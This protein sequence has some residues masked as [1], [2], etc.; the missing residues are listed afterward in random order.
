M[1]SSFIPYHFALGYDS[2]FIDLKHHQVNIQSTFTSHMSTYIVGI[3]SSAGGLEAL[4]A[5]LPHLHPNGLITYVIAQHMAHDGHSDLMEKLL[6]R[7]A[8]MQVKLVVGS[9]PLLPNHIYLIPAGSDGVVLDGKIDLQAPSPGHTSTP[10]VNVL[11]QSIAQSYQHHGIGVI[12]SGTGSDGTLGCRA[13]KHAQGLVIAQDLSSAG[14]DGMPSSAIEAGVVDHILDA[15]GIAEMISQTTSG[16]ISNDI[17]HFSN[18]NN[19]SNDDGLIPILALVFKKTGINFIGYKT[20]TLRRRLDT[21]IAGL[22]I[23]EL[24]AYYDYLIQ[25]ED[26]VFQLQQLFLVSFSSFFRDAESFEMLAHHLY[27]AVDRK[28]ENSAFNIWVPG[29]ASGEEVYTLAIILAEIQSK[30]DKKLSVNVRGTDLNPIA[31][32]QAKSGSY[33]LKAVKEIQDQFLQKYFERVGDAYVVCELIKSICQF[34][35]NNVIHDNE[36]GSIDLISCRNLLIYLKG[37]L[38]DQLVFKFHQA[39]IPDGMLFLGQSETLSPRTKTI[40]NPIDLTHR[41]FVRR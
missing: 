40:F 30:L 17:S 29:C 32:A 22:K 27:E 3:G 7:Y 18:T 19:Q 38:Q 6:N 15:K 16:T 5:L 21:R 39:L 1:R 25:D 14:F 36:T 11:F 2:I 28:I 23:N 24:S 4:F 9:E 31:L 26:E 41:L 35:Q 37:P 12:L 13:I 33:D 8:L 20:E 34:E 10:S